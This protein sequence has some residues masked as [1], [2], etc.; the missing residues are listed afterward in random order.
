MEN[1]EEISKEKKEIFNISRKKEETLKQLAIDIVENKVFTDRNLNKEEYNKLFLI[2]IPLMFLQ[3]EDKLNWKE[4]LG[5]FYE[6]Y[7]KAG[8][9]SINGSPIFYSVQLLHNK[10]LDL[11]QT[12]ID[13]YIKLKNTL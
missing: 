1:K 5:M 8:L 4:D 13:N 6:Y 12:F 10:D 3:K 7:D 2:F 11:L 9:G